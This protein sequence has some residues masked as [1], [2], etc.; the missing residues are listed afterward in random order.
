VSRII[1]IGCGQDKRSQPDEA[2]HLYTGQMFRARRAYAEA[3]GTDWFVVSAKAG[4]LHPTQVLAPYDLTMRDLPAIERAAWSLAVIK[5]VLDEVPDDN[6]R[7]GDVVLEL[8]LGADYA[9][10]LI[11]VAKA[12]GLS[13]DWPVE[14]LGIGQQRKWYREARDRLELEARLA[15]GVS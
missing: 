8:H 10:P 9:E 3:T 13:W 5:A 2:Q 11:E 6:V 15:G 7:L 1:L 12:I 14:G 4:L